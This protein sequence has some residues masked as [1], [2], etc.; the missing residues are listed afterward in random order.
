MRVL[1]TSQYFWPESFQINNICLSLSAKDLDLEVLTAKPNYPGGEVYSGYRAWGCAREEHHGININRI[2]LWPRGKSSLGLT[3]N[4]LSFVF[5]GILFGSWLMRRKKFDVIFVY[6]P[7]PILQAI[8]ALFLGRLK[9]CPV[10]LWVQDLWPDSLSATG[11]VP[12]RLLLRLV[13]K[14]VRFIY[15]HTDL[16]L[17]QSEAF[18]APVR[19]LAAN[20]PVEYHPNSV[21][22]DFAEGGDTDSP[23]VEGLDAGFPIMFAGN[24]GQAQAVGV[25]V[26]AAALLQE[27][28]EIQFVI[29]GEGSARQWMLDEVKKRGLDNVHL[30]GKF[31]LESMPGLMQ[32]ASG[33]LVTLADREIFAA[34][35]PSK[36]QAYLAAGKPIVACLNGEGGRLV[37]KAGAGF[38]TP[39]ENAE[40]LAD[41]I[42]RLYRTPSEQRSKMGSNGR[43]Y[44]QSHFN[45][46]DLIDKLIG[47]L[48]TITSTETGTV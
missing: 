46:E 21:N 12:N 37:E 11:Y 7:S 45:P 15:R 2:P 41:A 13:E 23:L 18:L 27:F 28:D 25:I 9:K 38:A 24:I 20:T 10:V 47:H 8:P 19:E 36:V 31:P 40:A 35:I 6:A 17:V 3:L 29:L 14:I 48:E 33:L 26:E 43:H 34:T 16:I 39:A 30:P 42:L 32:K 5:S 22:V 1:I 44:Y 4:Y